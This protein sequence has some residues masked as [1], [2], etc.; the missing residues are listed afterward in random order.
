[1][2][3][4]IKTTYKVPKLASAFHGTPDMPLWNPVKKHCLKES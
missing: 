1:V 3:K 2:V 4:I